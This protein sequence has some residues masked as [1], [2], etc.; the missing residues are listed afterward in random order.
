MKILVV[1]QENV[2]QQRLLKN[3]LEAIKELDCECQLEVIHDIKEIMKLEEYEIIITP[4][5]IVDNHIL[6]EGHIW[7]KEH[8]KHYLSNIIKGV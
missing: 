6:C 2:F 3:T 1:G 7:D 4:A 8:I 5:L